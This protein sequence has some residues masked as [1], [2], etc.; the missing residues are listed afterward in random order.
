MS[1]MCCHEYVETMATSSEQY[2]NMNVRNQF[3]EG[4]YSVD[5]TSVIRSASRAKSSVTLCQVKCDMCHY[6]YH[7]PT[8]VTTIT[9]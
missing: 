8:L 4:K 5:Y 1:F 2:V 7:S 9:T 6:T 3:G